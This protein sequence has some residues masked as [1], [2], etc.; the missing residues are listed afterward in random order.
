MSLDVTVLEGPVEVVIF[1][2]DG[3]TVEIGSTTDLVEVVLSEA[4]G[5]PGADGDPGPKGDQGDPGPQGEDGPEGPQGDPGPAGADGD[6][7][8]LAIG[9][10]VDGATPLSILSTDADGNLRDGRIAS[11]DSTF[12]G[13]LIAVQS[14]RS[15]LAPMAGAPSP[16]WFDLSGV[17]FPVGAAGVIIE[18]GQGAYFVLDIDNTSPFVA[19]TAGA[20]GP[21]GSHRI[22]FAPGGNAL[23]GANVLSMVGTVGDPS[24]MGATFGVPVAGVDPVDPTHLATLASVTDLIDAIDLPSSVELVPAPT[25]EGEVLTVVDVAGTLT[26]LWA[27]ASGGGGTPGG[28][29]NEIQYNDGGA[30]AGAGNIVVDGDG[31]FL[32]TVDKSSFVAIG[33]QGDYGPGFTGPDQPHLAINTVRLLGD[34]AGNLLIRTFLNGDAGLAVANVGAKNFV[35]YS[36]GITGFGLYENFPNTAAAVGMGAALGNNPV[37][38]LLVQ[39]EAAHVAHFAA[40]DTIR[41]KAQTDQTGKLI[42]AVDASNAEVFGVDLEGNLNIAGTL[43]G[44]ASD[45]GVGGTAYT[46]EDVV[47]ALKADSTL[48]P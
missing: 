45:G 34:G 29:D 37:A 8:E 42:R 40:I 6:D 20:F 27:P 9:A 5:P 39:P 31:L 7:A 33:P 10:E 41:A 38:R 28:S 19:Y 23:G 47:A 24:S 14:L 46:L 15:L 30:F 2:G 21:V 1:E 48:A 44:G 3:E 35:T 22:V 13:G 25:T 12:L 18:G 11:I 16:A 32:T 4:M 36:N 17:G 26:P 43:T